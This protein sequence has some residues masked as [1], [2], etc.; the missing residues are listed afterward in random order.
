MELGIGIQQNEKKSFEL[1]LSQNGSTTIEGYHCSTFYG[2]KKT[3]CVED[4]EECSINLI[5]TG[6][7]IYQGTIKSG[8]SSN[9]GTIKLTYDPI[10]DRIHFELLT[11]PEGEFYIPEDV[12]LEK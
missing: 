8:F 7:N 2:G 1:Y 4:T 11:E 10:H 9:V 12:Y 6:Q 5:K 3:D